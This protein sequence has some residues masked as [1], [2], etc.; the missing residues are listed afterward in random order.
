MKTPK[1]GIG[2]KEFLLLELK[3]NGRSSAYVQSWGYLGKRLRITYT[4]NITLA[5]KCDKVY[6]AGFK[7]MRDHIRRCTGRICHIL[8]VSIAE[9]EL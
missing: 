7:V 6:E 9:G 2:R 8:L 5:Y 4:S 3:T 1:R